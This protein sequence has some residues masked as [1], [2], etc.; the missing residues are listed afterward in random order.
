MA[1]A[2]ALAAE[3]LRALAASPRCKVGAYVDSLSK[4]DKVIWDEYVVNSP[5]KQR[6]VWLQIEKDVPFAASSFRSHLAGECRCR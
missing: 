2:L 3:R 4:G 6:V 5:L 1:T